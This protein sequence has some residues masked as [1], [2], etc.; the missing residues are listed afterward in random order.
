MTLQL[1]NGIY[2]WKKMV[3]GHLFARTTKTGDKKTAETSAAIWE[4]LALEAL[5][6]HSA[7]HLALDPV[8]R[9]LAWDVFGAEAFRDQAFKLQRH[10]MSVQ[11]SALLGVKVPDVENARH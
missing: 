9:T 8:R 5:G 3:N 2:H 4:R 10:R 7:R 11:V 1:R 6:R